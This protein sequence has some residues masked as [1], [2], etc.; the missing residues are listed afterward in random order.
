MKFKSQVFTQ[1]SGSIG[2]ITYAHNRGGLYTR[3][4]SIPVN[5]NSPGQ[6]AVRGF[7]STTVSHWINTLTQAERDAW[8][9]Y[10][11]NTPLTDRLGDPLTLTGQQM[12]VRCNVARL[13]GGLLRV[14]AGPTTF[15][16]ALL[17]SPSITTMV[18]P[19][20]LT[21][22]YDENDAWADIIG[23]GMIVQVGIPQSPTIN[24]FKGPYRF[25]ATELS[26]GGPLVP[27]FVM[28]TPFVFTAA[29]RIFLRIRSTESDGRIS[30]AQFFTAIVT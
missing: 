23:G 5:P 13:R 26:T 15:G 1:V 30:A 7:L 28:V 8:K 4:R 18:A 27:P 19:T 16:E 22:D 3:A 17:T 14:D 25:G 10:A 6:I 24:F 12:Y 2:G 9:L 29:Q 21:I 11:D 20:A